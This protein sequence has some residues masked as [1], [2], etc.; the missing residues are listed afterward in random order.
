MYNES[1]RID[2][3]GCGADEKVRQWMDSVANS[4]VI[5]EAD[6]MHNDNSSTNDPNRPILRSRRAASIFNNIGNNRNYDYGNYRG[7][8]EAQGRI[9]SNR[10]DPI[11]ISI[12]IEALQ[13]T[14][15]HFRFLIVV[16]IVREDIFN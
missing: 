11:L 14:N 10:Y 3:G 7:L 4:A 16:L 9:S 13:K 2:G 8:F 12:S 6:E 1:F 5:D 15:T